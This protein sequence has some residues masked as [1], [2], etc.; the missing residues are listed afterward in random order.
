[1]GAGSYAMIENCTSNDAQNMMGNASSQPSPPPTG[2]G[3]SGQKRKSSAPGNGKKRRH[4]NHVKHKIGQGEGAHG[5]PLEEKNPRTPESLQDYAAASAQLLA[6]T[7]FTPTPKALGAPDSRNISRSTTQGEKNCKRRFSILRPSPDAGNMQ[8]S[9]RKYS[10][11]GISKPDNVAGS[12]GIIENGLGTPNPTC[13]LDDIDENE[14]GLSS[15]FQ[16]YEIEATQHELLAPYSPTHSGNDGFSFDQDAIDSVLNSQISREKRKGKRK[17]R[18]SSSALGVGAEQEHLSGTG[19]H[20]FDIDFDAFDE[21]FADEGMQLANPFI[22]KSGYDLPNGTAHFEQRS[23]V[24]QAEEYHPSTCEGSPVH[25]EQQTELLRETAPARRSKKRKR[26]EIPNSLD[27]QIPTYVSPYPSNAGQQDRVLPGIEDIQV[28]SYLEIP[29]SQ[30]PGQHNHANQSPAHLSLDQTQP[31]PPPLEKPSKPRGNKRQSGGKRGKEYN[32]P[33]QEMSEKGGMFSDREIKVFDSFRDR[34]CEENNQS[35]TRFNELIQS[36]VRGNPE[37]TR[38][39]IAL[40]E[41][42]PYRTRQSVIRFCRRHFHNF[43]AR[44][45]WSEADDLALKDAVAKKGNSWKAVGAMIDRFPEDCR[46]RYR[47]YLINAE[48]RNTETWL[49]GEIRNLVMAV[50]Y[51]MQLLREQRLRARE[52]KYEGRDMPDSEPESDQDIQDMKL[53]NWQVVSDRMGGTR[54]RLQCSYKWNHMKNADRNEYLREIRRLEKGRTTRSDGTSSSWRLRKAM[55]KLK[56]I[57]SGDKL[58]ILQAFADCDAATESDIPWSSLGSKELRERW[59]AMDMKAALKSFKE[60][61]PGS[62]VMNYREVVNR[63]YTRVMA[64]DPGGFDDRWNP[65]LDGDVNELKHKGSR[66]KQDEQNRALRNGSKKEKVQADEARRQR[67]K[68]KSGR[69]KKIKSTLFVGSD[70]EEESEEDRSREASRSNKGSEPEERVSSADVA[71]SL[72]EQSQ[73]DASHE[74]SA[75]DNEKGDDYSYNDPSIAMTED[76]NDNGPSPHLVRTRVGSS[77][78]TKGEETSSDDSD[79]SLFNEAD[80]AGSKLVDQLQLLRDA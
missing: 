79:D 57:K 13:S 52:E 10:L 17:R 35:H 40:H 54:S 65:G 55:K 75:S 28:E 73:R 60:Q 80:G 66:K 3:R 59:S 27:S 18:S 6:E 78:R 33:L 38:L 5:P 32:P 12:D 77:H 7:A 64:D 16:E 74:E 50:D 71:N 21:I 46:D 56:N 47:N 24:S 76:N 63:I 62:E 53:I 8:A 20:A 15:L 45:I 19:Q 26:T 31:P 22:E 44:G 37:V 61:V 42:V 43:A 41:S 49:P 23:P 39:F 9:L 48:K 29:F 25:E 36:K 14:E 67:L 34:Y 72:E 69:E 1:M 11:K 2:I 68:Q 70:D 30:P 4:F 58:D 51:C